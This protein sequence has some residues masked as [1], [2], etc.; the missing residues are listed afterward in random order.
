MAGNNI[1]VTIGAETAGLQAQAAIAKATLTELSATTRTLAKEFVG[2]GAEAQSGLLPQLERSAT[3]AAAAKAE[4][5]GLNAEI[6][7]TGAAAPGIFSGMR[8]S[9]E[10]MAAPLQNITNLFRLAGEAFLVGFAVDKIVGMATRVGELGEH[11][12]NLSEETGISTEKLAALKFA[13]DVTGTS[14]DNIG[15]IV[16]RFGTNLQTSLTT[17]TGPAA[18]ALHALGIEQ[19]FVRQHS[20]DAALML[21]IVAQRLFEFAPGLNRA[22]IEAALFG[23]RMGIELTPALKLLAEDGF[24]GLTKKAEEFGGKLDALK[25]AESEKAIREFDA[26]MAG[27]GRTIGA[28]VL[29]GLSNLAQVMTQ[30]MQG[31]FGQAL[32]TD[33]EYAAKQIQ[34]QIDDITKKIETDNPIM[35]FVDQQRLNGLL[36]QLEQVKRIIDSLSGGIALRGGENP[37]AGVVPSKDAP[38]IG[39]EAGASMLEQLRAQLAQ[40]LALEQTSHEQQLEETVAFWQKALQTQQLS[41]KERLQVEIA[42]ANAQKELKAKQLTDL[43]QSNQQQTSLEAA[44]FQTKEEQIRA[45]FAAGKIT[46][47]QE[48]EQFRDVENE[49]YAALIKSMEARIALLNGDAQAQRTV[50]NEEA[51]AY[52]KHLQA[53]FKLDTQYFAAKKKL[54]EQDSANWKSLT[55]EIL[56]AEDQLVSGLFNA[57]QKLTTSLINLGSQLL[58]REI[59]NDLKAL[60]ERVLVNA[61]ILSSDKAT[62][63]GGLLWHLATEQTKTEA[64]VTGAAARQAAET[65][66][67]G[68]GLVSMAADAIKWIMNSAW[69]TF[70]GIFGFLAPEMGPAAVGPATAGEVLVAATAGNVLSA[71][72]GAWNLPGGL[73]LTHPQESILPADISGRMR[74]FFGGGGSA[75]GVNVHLTV[76]AVDGRSVKQFFKQNMPALSSSI[77]AAVR[78]GSSQFRGM[79]PR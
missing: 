60:T 25:I 20:N 43:V 32:A 53:L 7:A 41:A 13:T 79:A 22:A 16:V 4:L 24:A 45:D 68:L 75:G 40:Q 6:A 65:S 17:P 3:A 8:Q 33:Y 74:D 21:E 58:Q 5:A 30:I 66:S 23:Q 10:G 35:K 39:G 59:A 51:L 77:A 36:F 76:N 2:A 29:P 50:T 48:I 70:A 49:K 47:L 54:E 71:A 72:G 26:A 78:D 44:F 63:T 69:K 55:K 61:G 42:L 46:G 52:E 57:H 19:D 73:V 9:L 12:V 38:N 28:Q 31:H 18:R 34:Q 27:L 1:T 67:S 64:S 56:S 37:F 14:F 11:L 15:R 62:E